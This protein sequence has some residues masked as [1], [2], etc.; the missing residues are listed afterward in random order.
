MESVEIDSR[1]PRLCD[2]VAVTVVGT[3]A[4]PLR[5]GNPRIKVARENGG[6]MFWVTLSV[7]RRTYT[8]LADAP[9]T[10]DTG[11]GLP[12]CD[13]PGQGGQ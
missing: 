10:P 6:R 7:L 13:V 8:Q 5:P 3:A 2:G 1:W 12:T 4:D 9:D 11:S